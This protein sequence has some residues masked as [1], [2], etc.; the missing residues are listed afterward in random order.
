MQSA[1]LDNRQNQSQP[2]ESRETDELIA[3]NKVEGTKVYSTDG[4]KV[5]S[6]EHLMIGKRTGK[7]DYAVMSFGGFLGIGEDHH[8]LPWDVL[9]Y[10]TDRGGYVVNIDKEKLTD[11]PRY[12][13]GTE[14]EWSHGYNHKIYAFYGVPY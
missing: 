4:E 14:P 10:D 12:P 6:I 7:V 8:P 13:K 2:L 11:A 3:S 9:T 5:G 1:P